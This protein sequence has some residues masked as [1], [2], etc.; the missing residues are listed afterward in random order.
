M[1]TDPAWIKRMA[2]LED[3][4]FVSVGGWVT[5]LEDVGV[6]GIGARPPLGKLLGL[7][8]RE[9]KLTHEEFAV[10]ADIALTELLRIEN[11]PDYVPSPPAVARIARFLRVPETDLKML[12]GLL[13]TGDKQ[14]ERKTL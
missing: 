11:D 13:M 8:R 7:A 10:Q 12:A 2:E 3:G 14:L 5:A 6:P 9:M 1:N 4:S